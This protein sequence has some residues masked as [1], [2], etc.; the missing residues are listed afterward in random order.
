MKKQLRYSLLT[1]ILL[2]CTAPSFAW[3]QVVHQV[4]AQIAYDNLTTNAKKQANQLTQ[5]I[6]QEYATNQT[7]VQSANWADN[8][9]AR[10]I[11]A[12]STWHYVD[13]P[14]N[15]DGRQ[16]HYYSKINVIW[17]INQ[18]VAVLQ[19]PKANTFERALFLR[20]L[21]HFVGDIHQPLHAAN[22][23]AKRFPKGDAGGNLYLIKDGK[24]K[25]LHALWDQCFNMTSRRYPDASAIAQLAD[26]L[27]QHYPKA[28]FGDEINQMS[29]AQWAS[30][31]YT[32]ADSFVY[33]T[34]YNQ[35][36]SKAYAKQGQIICEQ[37]ITLAGYRLAK[38]LNS[39]SVLTSQL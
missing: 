23:Y 28:D 7:F 32:I 5:V 35:K 15:R 8:I 4:I 31:S 2:L 3:N 36:I 39:L 37:Q 26:Q 16:R 10:Q 27:Q 14:I 11:S 38:L 6:N 12:F 13:I 9:N 21:I 24:I 19:N 20:F 33:D 30:Q 22:L 34:P 18:A 29:P 1:I 17:A 25:N